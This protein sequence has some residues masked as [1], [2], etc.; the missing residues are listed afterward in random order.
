MVSLDNIIA[1]LARPS[2]PP[3]THPS[4]ITHHHTLL[5]FHHFICIS[6]IRTGS[7]SHPASAR[8]RPPSI[9][10]RPPGPK[11]P[12]P[13]TTTLS[14]EIHRSFL[15]HHNLPTHTCVQSLVY[16]PLLEKYNVIIVN[17][18]VVVVVA[19]AATTTASSSPKTTNCHPRFWFAILSLDRTSTT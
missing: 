2:P 19:T 6:S 7:R 10:Y 11:H 4:P 12:L 14:L 5:S 16:P 9:L 1:L 17:I 8:R 3:I 18:N 13:S 15:G